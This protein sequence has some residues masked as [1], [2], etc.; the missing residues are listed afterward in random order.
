MLTEKNTYSHRIPISHVNKLL[1]RHDIACN[2]NM[3][4]I[5]NPQSNHV[6]SNNFGLCCGVKYSDCSHGEQEIDVA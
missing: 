1:G 2:S 5:R 4:N 3:A 6:V